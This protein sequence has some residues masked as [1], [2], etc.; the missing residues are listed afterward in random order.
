MAM[1]QGMAKMQEQQNRM[2]E[3]SG[4]SAA[5]SHELFHSRAEFMPT[6]TNGSRADVVQ[7]LACDRPVQ[8]MPLTSSILQLL[9][10]IGWLVHFQFVCLSNRQRFAAFR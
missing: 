7:V 8:I 3:S 9:A 5:A 6:L 10:A 2:F 4:M 1:V